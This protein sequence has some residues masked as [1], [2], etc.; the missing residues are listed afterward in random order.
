MGCRDGA[1]HISTEGDRS[2]EPLAQIGG[3]GVFVAAL[4]EAFVPR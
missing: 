4:R 3:T 1:V 2:S